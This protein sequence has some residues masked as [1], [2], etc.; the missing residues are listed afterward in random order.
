MMM[1][2]QEDELQSKVLQALKLCQDI[3]SFDWR[4]NYL[5]SSALEEDDSGEEKIFIDYICEH[6]HC[7]VLKYL[8]EDPEHNNLL[9]KKRS[10]AFSRQF[11][12]AELIRALKTRE[13]GTQ[14]I[15]ILELLSKM[16]AETKI[17]LLLNALRDHS[18][19][20]NNKD[21]EIFN[22]TYKDLLNILRSL[23]EDHY[24]YAAINE[25]K[26]VYVETF[27]NVIAQSDLLKIDKYIKENISGLDS[28]EGEEIF[29]QALAV[30]PKNRHDLVIIAFLMIKHPYGY[31]HKKQEFRDSLNEEE[32]ATVLD[33]MLELNGN[34]QMIPRY[35]DFKTT[36]EG[37]S[38]DITKL[39]LELYAN[40]FSVSGEIGIKYFR[41]LMEIV[42]MNE[43]NLVCDL[44]S[45]ERIAPD[46]KQNEKGLADIKKNTIYFSIFSDQEDTKGTVI[47]EFCH[48]VSF[49]L[50]KNHA[51]PFKSND[52]ANKHKHIEALSK[53]QKKIHG[54][55]SINE[56][57]KLVIDSYETENQRLAELIVRVPHIVAKYGQEGI[58]ILTQELPEVL[59]LYDVFL[60]DCQHYLEHN[61]QKKLDLLLK[62]NNL[63][64]GQSVAKLVLDG[65]LLLEDKQFARAELKFQ[66]AI[67]SA[68]NEDL[69]LIPYIREQQ[70]ICKGMI[71]VMSNSIEDE[72]NFSGDKASK[73][74][75][76]FSDALSSYDS[77]EIENAKA[78][79]NMALKFIES[80]TEHKLLAKF[81][82]LKATIFDDVDSIIDLYRIKSLNCEE[83]DKIQAINLAHNITCEKFA[84]SEWVP[85]GSEPTKDLIFNGQRQPRSPTGE[86]GAGSGGLK[87]PGRSPC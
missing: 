18:L 45:I 25:A 51:I 41:P 58:T 50:Y 37:A 4:G 80:F 43:V 15:K 61:A 17:N 49:I 71:V 9:F 22:Y 6:D 68:S 28:A 78:S 82:I 29:S 11:P 66:E 23:S 60:E 81:L 40:P 75:T 3:N 30:K 26:Q 77:E 20:L 57:L 69:E 54:N 44:Q 42:A 39:Y 84:L 83:S 47:H 74:L 14:H 7:E 56:I 67:Q 55:E 16:P 59:D 1:P 10:N 32:I 79:I 63:Q 31:K 8:M 34:K 85:K 62:F 36:K 87:K 13:L 33:L 5:L 2:D 27:K 46:G 21:I 52:E 72:S 73:F 35:L 24:I 86:D 64:G 65:Q 53:L 12:T 19:I 38:G 76:H 70:V 48:M